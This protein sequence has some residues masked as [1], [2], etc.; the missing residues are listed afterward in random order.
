MEC[1]S[2]KFRRLLKETLDSN[3]FVT[4]TIALKGGGFIAE[5]KRRPDIKVFEIMQSN[6]DNLLLEILKDLKTVL[7]KL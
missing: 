4:A 3:K 5:I 6:R 2:D 1:F 7:K